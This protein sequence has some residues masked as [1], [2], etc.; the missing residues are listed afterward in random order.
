MA[1]AVV[2]F[3]CGVGWIYNVAVS[4]VTFFFI[5]STFLLALRH[6]FGRFSAREYGRFVVSHALRIYPL[7]W[8]GLALLIAIAL[9]FTGNAIDWGAT[10]LSALL[11]HSW[12]PVHYVHYGLNPVAWYLCALLFC[13]LIYPF[14][15]RWLGKWRLRYKVALAIVM[16]I[17]L[18]IILFPLDIPHREAVF[19]NPLSHVLDVTVG[20][21]LVHLYHILKKRFQQV[22]YGTATLIEFLALLSLAAVIAVN[23]CTTWIRPWEDVII[24]L[25]PQ[26]AILL[27]LALLNGQEGAIGRFMLCKP[28]QWLGSISFEVYVLQFAAFH[29]FGY[30]LSPLAAHFG[31]EIYGKLEWFAMPLLLPL[32]GAVNRWFTRPVNAF[33]KRKLS[34]TKV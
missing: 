13:Y 14:M 3:H 27:A 11:V 17:V 8:L 4:G 6:P 24:W 15:S 16:A 21:S 33:V 23:V 10:A 2:L 28:L 9:L 5:S 18:G 31:W 34:M 26:G 32:A 30:V 7:H 20:L 29:L 19:V 25:L 22:N 12:S 1:I